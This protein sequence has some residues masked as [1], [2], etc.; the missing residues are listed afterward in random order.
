M[1]LPHLTLDLRDRFRSQVVD[2][3]LDGYAD[4]Q[5][6]NPCVRCNGQV[7][8]DAMLELASALGAPRLATGHY[9]RVERDDRGPL[10]RAAADPAKDQSYMLARLRPE[11]LERLWFPLG[12]LTKPEVR[13]IAGRAGL[14]VA[15]KPESQDLCF[16]AG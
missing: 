1:D 10:V 5:T 12:G 2:H 14:P 6:P 7:R 8:F 9:A 15:S 11:A 13:D 3:F 16:L 4:G